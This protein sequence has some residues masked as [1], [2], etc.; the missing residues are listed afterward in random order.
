MQENTSTTGTGLYRTGE[1][2]YKGALSLLQRC[3]QHPKGK[4]FMC[5]MDPLFRQ[6]GYYSALRS[7]DRNG[8]AIDVISYEKDDLSFL[9]GLMQSD[10]RLLRIPEKIECGVAIYYPHGASMWDERDDSRQ[11]LGDGG[12]V[13]RLRARLETR[14]LARNFTTLWENLE[15]MHKVKG[16]SY[17]QGV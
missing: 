2:I 6:E 16:V 14:R 15:M 8:S 7:Y 13:H 17:F 12:L 10:I 4:L 3:A 11:L 5:G 1:A 9:D